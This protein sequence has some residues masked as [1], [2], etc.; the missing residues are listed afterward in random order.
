DDEVIRVPTFEEA[1]AEGR[2]WG[3]GINVD[4]SKFNWTEADCTAVV[5]YL[6]RYG[7]PNRSFFVITNDDQ[8]DLLASLY[9]MVAVTWL[10][11]DTDPSANIAKARKYTNAFVTYSNSVI[12]DDL[13][14]AYRAENIPVFVHSCNTIEDLYKY[15]SK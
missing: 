8:R 12:T 7:L 1:C 2:R 15:A 4:C 3:L 13:I 10:T 5:G 9:P 11:S 14:D 6:R